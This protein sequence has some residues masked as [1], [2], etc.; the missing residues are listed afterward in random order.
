M[1]SRGVLTP[2]EPFAAEA[3][4]EFA[5]TVETRGYDSLWLPELFGREP[6]ATAG[7]LLGRTQR[8]AV[9]SGIANVYVRDANAMA[10]AR[11]ALAELSG[12]RFMLGLGVSNTGL[13]TSCGH[14]WQPPLEK[15]AAALDAM[16]TAN[17]ASPAPPQPCPTFIAAHGPLLQVLGARRTSGIIT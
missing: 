12:G 7:F 5:H 16:H 11:Q 3:L 10:Q 2:T 17:V 6:I 15:M 8:I 14:T 9:A 1:A 13:N 4:V